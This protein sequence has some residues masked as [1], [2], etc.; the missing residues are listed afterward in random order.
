L[1]AFERF[2]I[3]KY[4]TLR[5]L[6]ILLAFVSASC[7][8]QFRRV[9]RSEDWR[10]K[11]EAGLEYYNKK[12][13]YHTALLFEDIRPVVRGLP[14]GEKV[15]FYLAYCQYNEKTYLLASSQFKSFYETYGRSTLYEEAKFMYAYS[16][17]VGSPRYNLDQRSSL[18]AMEA[19]QAFV[20]QHPDSKFAEQALDVIKTVQLRLEQK[21]FENAK[22]YLRIGMYK[23]A[24]VSLDHFRREFPDSRFAEEAAFCRVEAQFKLAERSLPNLQKQ[25]YKEVLDLYKELVDS[26]PNSNFLRDAEKFYTLST[27]RYNKLKNNNQSNS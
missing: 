22:Q 25:R 19:M 16:L 24:L 27:E 4:N 26:F 5:Y 23:A 17:Y 3:A 20:N 9:Q 8:T 15:E 10:V 2:N 12:D 21:G 14:E 1:Q 18:E 7:V 13:Y 11:Y 6:I